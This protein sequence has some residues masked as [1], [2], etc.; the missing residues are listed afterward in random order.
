MELRD[1]GELGWLL[2]T[3]Y[4]R[5][6]GEEAWSAVR[7]LAAR[8]VAEQETEEATTATT[9]AA[10]AT[11]VDGDRNRT[12]AGVDSSRTSSGRQR[13]IIGLVAVCAAIVLV[14]LVSFIY[15]FARSAR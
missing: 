6:V 2:P 9:T 1:R 14:F 5:P 3:S 7:V 11:T 4:I 12:A 10:A 15:F 13:R 8:I